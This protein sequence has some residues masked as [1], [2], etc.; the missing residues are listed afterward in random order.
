MPQAV[1]SLQACFSNRGRWPWAVTRTPELTG[2]IWSDADDG[3]SSL[4]D[5]TGI[6]HAS[7]SW[8]QPMPATL[9]GK[10]I[11]SLLIPNYTHTLPPETPPPSPPYTTAKPNPLPLQH[12]LPTVR[13]DLFAT[14]LPSVSQ[15]LVCACNLAL[16]AKVTKARPASCA[17]LWNDTSLQIFWDR[18]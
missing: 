18:N 11:H 10:C 4:A 7:I 16:Q 8:G 5:L 14:L 6:C 2:R 9:S 3:K 13:D 12:N 17:V 1:H 15:M